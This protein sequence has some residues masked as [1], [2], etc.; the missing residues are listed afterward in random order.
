MQKFHRF[1]AAA[2]DD[3]IVIVLF[4]KASIQILGGIFS[5]WLTYLELDFIKVPANSHFKYIQ[6][7]MTAYKQLD[8]S[9]S[10]SLN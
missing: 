9:A 1:V 8:L 7:N 10:E 5:T 3:K 6:L 2:P 4:E